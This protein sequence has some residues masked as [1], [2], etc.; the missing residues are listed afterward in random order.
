MTD[1]MDRLKYESLRETTSKTYLGIWRNFNKFLIRLDI[2]PK[3]W[4]ERTALYCTYLIEQGTQSSTVKSYVSAI[5]T[6]L[7]YDRYIWDQNGVL[8]EALIKACKLKN[9][10]VMYR[11]PIKVGL[12]EV[13]LFRSF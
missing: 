3:S 7:K 10:R 12:L 9:D 4:E 6:T 11:F 2:K 13:L 1:I 5:K 8:L